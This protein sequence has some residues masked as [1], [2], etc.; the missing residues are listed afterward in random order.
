MTSPSWAP[1]SPCMMNPHGIRLFIRNIR[2]LVP[3]HPLP[4]M[5]P[6]RLSRS[7]GA[8]EHMSRL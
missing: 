7:N 1:L 5:D 6:I 8:T 3:G 2:A 4:L